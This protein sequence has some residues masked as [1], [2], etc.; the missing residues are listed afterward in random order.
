MHRQNIKKG[1]GCMCL[2]KFAMFTLSA[3]IAIGSTAVS[4]AQG[5]S[6]CP[7]RMPV[8]LTVNEV[9]D[10]PT[11]PLC[12]VQLTDYV[13]WEVDAGWPAANAKEFWFAC[14]RPIPGTDP[15]SNESLVAA[16]EPVKVGE[17]VTG[18]VDYAHRATRCRSILGCHHQCAAVFFYDWHQEELSDS[19]HP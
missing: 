18:V 16:L 8:S 7:Q 13:W 5:Y 2:K 14:S 6:P 9:Q 15:N 4:H 19:N 10:L 11:G 17:V 3:M 1:D 12:K